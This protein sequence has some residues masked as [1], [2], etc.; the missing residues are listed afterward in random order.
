M[1]KGREEG[2]RK[3]FGN[4][5][6]GIGFGVLMKLN[7]KEKIKDYMR[8]IKLNKKPSKESFLETLKICALGIVVLGVIGLVFYLISMILG[9]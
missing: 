2:Y 7:I 3:D 9:L 4:R 5:F 8:V 1:D 6:C